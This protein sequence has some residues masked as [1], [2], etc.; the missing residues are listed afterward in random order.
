MLPKKRPK[1]TETS[2]V[3]QKVNAMELISIVPTPL[4]MDK[5]INAS[6]HPTM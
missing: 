3:S 5:K 1:I 4:I 6:V 2:A